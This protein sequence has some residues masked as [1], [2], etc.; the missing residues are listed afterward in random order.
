M[1][2]TRHLTDMNN[3]L[4]NLDPERRRFVIGLG[5]AFALL[6]LLPISIAVIATSGDDAVNKSDKGSIKTGAPKPNK[7]D[8][9][10]F[11]KTDEPAPVDEKPAGATPAGKGLKKVAQPKLEGIEVYGG[12][13]WS[14]RT[15][16]AR[17]AK[18]F[19]QVYLTMS[20]RT[21]KQKINTL[22]PFTDQ[23]SL[24]YLRTL[25]DPGEPDYAI[26][27]KIQDMLFQVSPQ[28]GARTV[29]V[30]YKTARGYSSWITLEFAPDQP[31]IV[32]YEQGTGT[33]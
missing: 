31:T 33:Y 25:T 29:D 15:V 32:R 18:Q 21:V 9:G 12:A 26:G 6:V 16:V 17:R 30:S 11:L 3:P 10:G 28:T 27:G 2:P 19:T 22:R 4:R 1:T 8:T 14:D 7:N 20:S 24:E 23:T 13:D 5:A